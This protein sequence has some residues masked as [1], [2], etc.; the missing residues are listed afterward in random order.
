MVAIPWLPEDEIWFPPPEQALREPDGLLAAGGDLSPARLLQAYR[1][2][3][4]PWFSDGEPILWWSPEPRCVIYP[5]QQHISRSLKR[6]LR[7]QDYQ[8]RYDTA[9]AAVMSACAEPRGDGAGTWI[10]AEMRA[11]Y[12]RLHQL[13]HAH[14]VEIWRQGRLIGGLYGIAIGRIFFGESMFS[15]EPNGSKLAITH[16]CQRLHQQGYYLLDCQVYSDHLASLGAVCISRPVFLDALNRGAAPTIQ[17]YW[18]RQQ[19]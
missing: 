12:Q 2:G 9:F 15:A 17:D 11:A 16:L 3:I 4:F 6:R 7:K 1:Q 18:Y 5:A 8:V 19:N 13:G 10:T 14:S